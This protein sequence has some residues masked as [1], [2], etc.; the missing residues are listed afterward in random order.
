[1]TMRYVGNINGTVNRNLDYEEGFASVFPG[2]GKFSEKMRPAN[3][4]ETNEMVREISFIVT[5]ECKSL[6]DELVMAR[7]L[8]CNAKHYR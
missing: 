6:S 4:K 5:S 2:C 3:T 1:M 7:S 8:L